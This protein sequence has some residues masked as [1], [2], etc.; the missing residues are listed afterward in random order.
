MSDGIVCGPGRGRPWEEPTAFG[1][2]FLGVLF[3]AEADFEAGANGEGKA[4]VAD[5]A[6]VLVVEQVV[7]F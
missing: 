2:A 5:G 3:A 7:E 1:V 4:G 6:D